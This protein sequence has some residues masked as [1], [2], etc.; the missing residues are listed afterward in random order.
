MPSSPSSGSTEVQLGGEQ[1]LAWG[2]CG[3]GEHGH[4][5]QGR[6]STPG[7]LGSQDT[8][9]KR[10]VPRV[11]T[12]SCAGCAPREGNQ[13]GGV[14][15]SPCSWLSPVPGYRMNLPRGQPFAGCGKDA[16]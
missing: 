1:G 16:T 2:V 12:N 3:E 14:G 5:S 7:W 15:F 4:S 13:T 9:N 11:T 6:K 10:H 8:L